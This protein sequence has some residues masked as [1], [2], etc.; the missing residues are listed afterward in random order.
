MCIQKSAIMGVCRAPLYEECMQHHGHK[1]DPGVTPR[2]C[3]A[4]G[5]KDQVILMWAMAPGV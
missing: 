2:T 4:I 1:G 3:G 5:G